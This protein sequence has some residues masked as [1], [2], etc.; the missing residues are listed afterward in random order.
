MSEPGGAVLTPENVLVR[1]ESASVRCERIAADEARVLGGLF[2][3][4]PLGAIV[5]GMH[6]DV[7]GVEI[8]ASWIGRWLGLGLVTEIAPAIGAS[9]TADE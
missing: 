1:R 3:G 5:D 8:V 4:V 9:R 6:A 7:L 2:A